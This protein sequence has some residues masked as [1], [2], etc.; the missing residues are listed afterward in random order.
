MSVPGSAAQLTATNGRSR[1]G[2]APVDRARDEL[3][4]GARLARQEDGCCP[5]ARPARRGGGR[6]SG[7]GSARRSRRSPARRAT[8]SRSTTFSASTRSLRREISSRLARS[9]RS[10]RARTIA[11]ARISPKRRNRVRSSGDQSRSDRHRRER[12]QPDGPVPDA[13]RKHEV[14]LDAVLCH[15]LPLRGP[16]LRD[17]GRPAH[18]EPEAFARASDPVRDETGAP[19]VPSGCPGWG[20]GRRWR[21][22]SR[23]PPS[24][25]RM[26][27]PRSA[28]KK[29]ARRS[30]AA[31]S[32][33][34]KASADAASEVRP[35]P[36]QASTRNL[37]E[38]RCASAWA[39]PCRHFTTD[40]GISH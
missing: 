19:S 2:A 22:C 6:A 9:S 7:R 24:S 18:R 27:L 33:V 28:S 31:S 3:L 23:L 15:E 25:N 20:P 38:R 14:R 1:A 35:K 21:R 4:A 39:S 26:T 30:I 36:P 10:V 11:L 17:V 29:R 37:R 16:G 12:E 8:S 5:S 32:S 13:Q 34:S 40:G